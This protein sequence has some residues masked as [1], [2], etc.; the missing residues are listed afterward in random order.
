MARAGPRIGA[1]GRG[2]EDGEEVGL[3]DAFGFAD[4]R[5]GARA[6]VEMVVRKVL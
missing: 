5:K 6:E 4:P 3:G 1:R 2:F